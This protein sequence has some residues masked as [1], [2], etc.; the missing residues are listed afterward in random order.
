ME[1][2]K[3]QA[4][5]KKMGRIIKQRL[6]IR[7]IEHNIAIRNQ[8]NIEQELL[9]NEGLYKKLTLPLLENDAKLQTIDD[10]EE[11]DIEALKLFI[12]Q[13]KRVFRYLF[14]KYANSGFSV[15]PKGSFE[16]LRH[17]L[18]TISLAEAIK[19]L[20]DH[21]ITSNQ[22]SQVEIASLFRQVNF[23]ILHESNVLSLNYPGFIEFLVQ[24]AIHIFSKDPVYN[25]TK[26][27]PA[28]YTKLLFNYFR[29]AAKLKGEN[30]VLYENPEATTLGDPE[31]IQELTEYVTS[32]PSY[33]LPEGYKKVE[34]KSIKEQ[35]TI[36]KHLQFPENLRICIEVMDE[37]LNKALGVHILEPITT[38]EY[39]TRIV[40]TI[41]RICQR[42]TYE[43]NY[44]LPV[45]KRLRSTTFNKERHNFSLRQM[46]E[47]IVEPKLTGKMKVM[48]AE[49][50]NEMKGIVKEIAEIVSEIVDAV[51]CN[52]TNIG[53][54]LK[55]GPGIV[56]NRVMQEKLCKIKGKEIEDEKKE[57]KRK[58]RAVI[59]KNTLQELKK[60]KLKKEQEIIQEL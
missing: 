13:H 42:R 5:E 46:N 6:D 23:K 21:N 34:E 44:M 22:I 38:Y 33:P 19:M 16:E 4:K 18:D 59:L 56:L 57:Q 50:K 54:K 10:E 2:S 47:K 3:R 51:V 36:P 20:K 35:Y 41:G 29:Q 37:I 17:K 39:K 52:R 14:S 53:T 55:W 26:K 58:L 7:N 8:H 49:A 43:K 11:R 15:K 9:L 48:V 30:I 32:N 1:E 25:S 45:T 24:A 28:D 12:D 40:P 60:D 27:S 31:V